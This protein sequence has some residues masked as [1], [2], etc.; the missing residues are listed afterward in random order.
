MRRYLCGVPDKQCEGSNV[1]IN[2]TGCKVHASS[3]EAFKCYC[4]FLV[5]EGYIK[6]GTREFQDPKD[7]YIRVLTKPSHFGAPLRLGKLGEGGASGKGKRF[8]YIKPGAQGVL[9]S[10]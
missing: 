7:G 3:Q 2:K 10:T 5:Q 6:V 8:T 4:R 9:L 1:T